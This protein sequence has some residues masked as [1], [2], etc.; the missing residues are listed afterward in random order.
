MIASIFVGDNGY[1]LELQ[2]PYIQ[3]YRRTH[4]MKYG[5]KLA[6][7]VICLPIKLPIELQDTSNMQV[8]FCAI[9]GKNR[10]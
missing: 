9:P 8:I 7:V 4:P 6:M 3:I 1:M 5:T 2:N 10:A